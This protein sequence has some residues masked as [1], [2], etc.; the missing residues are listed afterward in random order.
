MSS[1]FIDVPTVFALPKEV[2]SVSVAVFRYSISTSFVVPWLE[3]I[4]INKIVDITPE[5][6]LN[7][8]DNSIDGADT[9]S[10]VGKLVLSDINSDSSAFQS[11]TLDDVSCN[12]KS[13]PVSVSS[14][15]KVQSAT[16]NILELK[17]NLVLFMVTV[18]PTCNLKADNFIGACITICCLFLNNTTL[19]ILWAIVDDIVKGISILPNIVSSLSSLTKVLDVTIG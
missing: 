6:D 3:D 9:V 13:T 1:N 15:T 12:I 2:Y 11:N 7:K 4:F 17:P 19:A 16:W 10:A 14:D 18:S 8:S 5:Y